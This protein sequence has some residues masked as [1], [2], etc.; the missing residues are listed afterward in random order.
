MATEWWRCRGTWVAAR[1]GYGV[2][3]I[4]GDDR[5]VSDDDFARHRVP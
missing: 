2:F 1:P 4:T 3:A 5:A